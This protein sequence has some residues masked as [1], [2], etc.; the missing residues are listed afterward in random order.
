MENKWYVLKVTPGKE[1]Q[2]NENFNTL[3]ALDRMGYVN[4]FICPM[5]KEFVVLRKKKVLRDKILYSGYLYFETQ[6][7][8]N[9][10]ELKEI[11]SHPFV[12]S[13][14]GDKKPRLMG[15]QDINKIIKDEMLNEHKYVKSITFA[16]GED[17]VLTDGPFASFNGTITE[18]KG[19]KVELQV[20]IF[21]R[22]TPVTI[23]LQNIKKI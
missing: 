13:M 15:R 19:D 3:I 7:E 1:R 21:G 9:D 6:R 10:N 14:L 17:V 20:K 11:S 8:L 22:L 5:E 4:R 12:M 2:M 16:V 18:I 23:D